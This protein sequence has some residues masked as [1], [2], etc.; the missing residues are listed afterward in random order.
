[1]KHRFFFTLLAT[2][3][4]SISAWA[5]GPQSLKVTFD[6]MDN[7]G[8]NVSSGGSIISTENGIMNVQMSDQGSNKYRA[9]LQYQTSGTYTFDKSKD[10][11]WAVKLTGA[12]PGSSNS[13]KFELNYKK[14]GNNT[15]INGISGPT[16][17]I[18]C[19]DGGRIYYFNLGA[20]GLNKL[21]DVP[22]GAQVLNNIHFIFADAVCENA[23]QARYGVDWVASFESVND[24]N[25]FKDWNDEIASDSKYP[26]AEFGYRIKT[27]NSWDSSTPKN[28]WS[29]A[30]LEA[31]YGS[32]L[33]T[34]ML[35]QIENFQS[36][37]VYTLSLHKGGG[38]A[39]ELGVW[40]FP[41]A[42]IPV[43]SSQSAATLAG[44]AKAVT[45][46]GMD[47]TGEKINPITTSTCNANVWTFTMSG[48]QLTPIST[49]ANG[50]SLVGLL[51]T[52]PDLKNESVA[53]A[54]IAT[55]GNATASNYPTL[56]KT[57]T[58]AVVNTTKMVGYATLEAAVTAA[59]HNDVLEVYENVELGSRINTND[60]ALTI[61]GHTGTEV[62]ARKNSY[63]NGLMFLTTTNTNAALTVRNLI[64][65]G[66]NMAT[67]SQVFEASNGKPTILENVTIQNV[68]VTNDYGS[69]I[70]N[71]SSGALTLNNVTF[72]NCTCTGG[73]NNTPSVVFVGSYHVT[74]K[75]NNQF[76]NC[77]EVPAIR[78]ENN[79]YMSAEGELTNTTP[80]TIQLG[81]HIDGNSVVK[82]CTD[83]SKFAL[84]NTPFVL[85]N[86]ADDLVAKD[87]ILMNTT[88]DLG[89]NTLA[90]AVAAADADDVI[91]IRK[92]VTVS[93]NRVEIKK[94]L[95][96][97]G[98]TGAEKMICGVPANQLMILAN[99]ETADYDVTFKNLVVDGQNTL[100]STQ[101]F[102]ANNKG[103]FVFE[104]VSVINSNYSVVTGDVKS[105]NREV[106]LKG[107]NSFSTGIYLNMNKRVSNQNTTHTVAIPL[108]LANDYTEDY[109]IVT[110]CDNA[111]LYTAIGATGKAWEL[112]MVTSGSNKELKGRIAAH[113]YDLN[114]SAAGMAT[115]VLGFDVPMLPAG[116]KAYTLT[117]DGSADITATE[118]TAIAA[119]KPVLII[120]K[121][122]TYT[123]ESE[124]GAV[125]NEQANPTNGCLVGTYTDNTSIALSA[126]PKFNY[127]LANGPSGVGFYQVLDGDYTINRNRAYLTCGYNNAAP[128]AAP[129][130]IRF[131]QVP[132]QLDN[133]AVVA[134]AEKLLIDGKLYIRKADRTYTIDGQLMK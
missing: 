83:K 47:M 15:W 89:Y 56:E 18:D 131:P 6:G 13:R 74:L 39:G 133:A 73:A 8:W 10:I 53:N 112:Y 79:Y 120:A 19:N 127:I 9:D 43:V 55:C 44:Y 132:T 61:Q 27:D 69:V 114:V 92:D 96:I 46:V 17:Q 98:A 104:N 52:T 36:N 12:L 107:N 32:R 35:F 57:G 95:T 76:I 72:Q 70:C 45:G 68:N 22:A 38:G 71:K 42:D 85:A 40:N 3:L 113:S 125:L 48:A 78:I 99:G 116:V 130:R 126:A 65:D 81:T 84:V 123:F 117:N 14:E 101:I 26:V 30:A 97:Q 94:A 5:I 60:R 82:S 102:D 21:G 111:A 23:E 109:A 122:G 134:P 87:Y 34:I 128:G 75:G 67:T 119:N 16:G 31:R 50:I 41:H 124:A 62:I 106:V 77:G 103:R 108:I 1:M 110:T 33:F 66:N 105:N 64:V 28:G 93:S 58:Y 100:R 121:A 63:T 115:L 59:A 88:Q 11:V 37:A 20:D 54:H 25:A 24:L 90:E 7:A 118:E 51:V 2:A 91:E 129:M 29:N 49:D 80:I 86:I 4:M